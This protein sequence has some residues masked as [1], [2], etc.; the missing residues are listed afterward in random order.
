[1]KKSNAEK[2][3]VMLIIAMFMSVAVVVATAI[4]GFLTLNQIRQ[5]SSSANSAKAIFAADAGLEWG[6]CAIVY[7]DYTTRQDPIGDMCRDQQP[8]HDSTK[9]PVMNPGGLI[10]SV[11]PQNVIDVN[12]RCRGQNVPDRIISTGRVSGTVRALELR[13]RGGP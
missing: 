13:F 10:F 6:L 4:V 9:C 1:M 7:P 2:G 11:A 5:S 8:Y 3:Q 12:I